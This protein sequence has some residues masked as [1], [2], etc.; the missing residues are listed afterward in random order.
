MKKKKNSNTKKKRMISIIAAATTLV[1]VAVV[2]VVAWK[3]NDFLSEPLSNMDVSENINEV[4]DEPITGQFNV[5][6]LGCDKSE[7]R[8][9]T[10]MLINVDK[11]NK[12]IRMISIPRDTK[13][14]FNNYNDKINA[15][16]PLGGI[17]LLIKNVKAL[18]GAPIHYYVMVS[19]GALAQV[20]DAL[21]GVEYNVERDMKYS[22]PY[23]DLY[24]DLKAGL[25][26]L[27]GD[28]AEQ[29]C[30]YRSYVMGDLTRT[31][32]QQKFLKALI[33]QKL[34]LEYID[35]IPDV[36]NAIK[37]NIQT[38][39]TLRTVLGNLRV[40]EML[41]EGVEIELIEV[42]G[43][44]ND[45]EKEHISYYLI[46]GKAKDELLSICEEKFMGSG[47]SI[48]GDS[49]LDSDSSTTDTVS[50]K[51]SNDEKRWQLSFK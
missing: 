17:E 36:F 44:F 13:V 43:E 2:A 23:Q 10:I 15:S 40:L 42:P 19:P 25:Q 41:S 48:V 24:I 35:R 12:S 20:V 26:I 27:N 7:E 31:E 4:I 37:A 32:H 33:E 47:E 38:N 3:I 34:K 11:T 21:G 49:A 30:R 5:L 39:V 16:V 8:T 28:Q 18:T 22:D 9:D 50:D 29:Y 45:M 6:L 14:R 51:I 1:V 46:E